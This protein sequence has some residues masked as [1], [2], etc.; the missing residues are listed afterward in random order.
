MSTRSHRVAHCAHAHSRRERERERKPTRGSQDLDASA[1]SFSDLHFKF[2]RKT[3]GT[4]GLT[5]PLSLP[6]FYLS[7][8]S[9]SLENLC[10]CDVTSNSDAFPSFSSTARARATSRRCFMYR[11]KWQSSR[12]TFFLFV[13]SPRASRKRKMTRHL[14]NRRTLLL[15]V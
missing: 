2:G 6:F 12:A 14:G 10:R 4:R 1:P 3:T 9:L 8:L 15:G 11:K 7:S 5:S 13:V